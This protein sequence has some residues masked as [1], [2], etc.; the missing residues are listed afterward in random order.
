MTWQ[1]K[2]SALFLAGVVLLAVGG[3]GLLAQQNQQADG[4]KEKEV[5]YEKIVFSPD[6]EHWTERHLK[7]LQAERDVEQSIYLSA[8]QMVRMQRE[9]G[10][11]YKAIPFLEGLAKRSPSQ[12]L[13]NAVRRLI[14]EI[15]LDDGDWKKAEEQ[16]KLIIEE[17]LLQI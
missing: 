12:P 16:L 5:R 10:D 13:R 1:G 15:A 4:A 7:A 2:I 14:V 8:V 3:P 9:Q 6:E 11:A 17:S